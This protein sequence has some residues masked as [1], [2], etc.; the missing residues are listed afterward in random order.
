LAST[1][2]RG[3]SSRRSQP[4]LNFNPNHNPDLSSRFLKAM[5]RSCSHSTRQA[6]NEDELY[7][8]LVR[9]TKGY[10]GL[11][12]FARQ[13]GIEYKYLQMMLS[14][15]SRVSAEVAA[16][17]GWELRWVKKG[18]GENVRAGQDAS[19]ERG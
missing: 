7:S 6:Q 10:G 9:A 13:T 18:E 12:R 5:P 15:S 17:L 4:S 11:V 19:R 3:I 14:R 8:A 1:I 2:R 16:W